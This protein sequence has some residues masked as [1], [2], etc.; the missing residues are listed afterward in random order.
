[1]YEPDPA[2][3]R[4]E[5]AECQHAVDKVLHGNPVRDADQLVAAL[6]DA[7]V[8]RGLSEPTRS[9]LEARV[10]EAQDGSC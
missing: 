4:R 8:Q 2:T 9:W 10:R 3:K 6:R 7:I 5:D 1:M